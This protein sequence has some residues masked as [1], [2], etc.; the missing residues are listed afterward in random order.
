V[1]WT[2]APLQLVAAL[3]ITFLAKES[4]HHVSTRDREGAAPR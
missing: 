1:F 3:A 4:L 2:F